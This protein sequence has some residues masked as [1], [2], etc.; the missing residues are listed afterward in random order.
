MGMTN[1]YGFTRA[2]ILGAGLGT[3]LRP[4]TSVL[5]KPLMPIY[6]HSLVEYAMSSCRELGIRD[7][8]INTHHLPD[9]WQ[10]RFGDGGWQDCSV[11][12]SHEPVL[13]DSGGGLRQIGP[14]IEKDRSLLVLN[15]DILT[16]M[17]LDCLMETHRAS[18][19][20]MTMALRSAGGVR[21]VGFDPSSGLVTDVRHGLG[22]DPGNYQF[23]G[24]YCIEPEVLSMIP[25]QPE[26]ISIVPTWLELISSGKV[27]G[28]V[29]DEG[30][31][32]DV[33]SP[34][35]YREAHRILPGEMPHEHFERIGKGA[36]IHES[37]F[38][39]ERT[40]V[41]AGAVIGKD[42]RLEDCIVWPDVVVPDGTIAAQT[43]LMNEQLEISSGI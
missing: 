6:H 29:L 12:L 25:S 41:G 1:R 26:V 16:T 14:M 20:L 32:I 30:M 37:S 8:V 24:V 10:S 38:V 15:G 39:D 19:A 2:F 33:G 27:A 28:V 13:L 21:N 3:R 11:S 7:F 34:E 17:N 35:M 23:A 5:P 36:V 43:V 9:C 40:I 22:I 42:C 4:L 31:W 18:G